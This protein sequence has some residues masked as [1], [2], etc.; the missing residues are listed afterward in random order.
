MDVARI[1]ESFRARGITL[2][3][4]NG[5]LS[6]DHY[7]ELTEGDRELIRA[8]KKALLPWLADVTL[9]PADGRSPEP[10]PAELDERGETDGGRMNEPGRADRRKTQKAAPREHSPALL[11]GLF[12]AEPDPAAPTPGPEDQ[13]SCPWPWVTPERLAVAAKGDELRRRGWALPLCMLPEDARQERA[14]IMEFDGGLSREAAERAAGLTA[15][16][17]RT[18]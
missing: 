17:E 1:L 9:V 6:V 13:S 11:P 15:P 2:A 14:A 5:N 8:H 7:S 16:R 12:R 3:V 4:D 10:N 18:A